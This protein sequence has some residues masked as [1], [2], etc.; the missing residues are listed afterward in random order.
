MKG[1]LSFHWNNGRFFPKL[2]V[3]L[4]GRERYHCFL[5]RKGIPSGAL[6][7]GHIANV[8]PSANHGSIHINPSSEGEVRCDGGVESISINCVS[9][10]EFSTR[11]TSSFEQSFKNRTITGRSRSAT[12]SADCSAQWVIVDR[13]SGERQR[14]DATGKGELY[15]SK[16][17]C[18]SDGGKGMECKGPKGHL[19]EMPKS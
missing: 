15:Y 19:E 16:D 3:S 13:K 9:N 10:G 5:D 4:P 1:W 6:N 7:F 17:F 2:S 18:R 14:F 8:A 11:E 12:E